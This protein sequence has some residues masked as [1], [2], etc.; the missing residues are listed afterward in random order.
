MDSA[1]HNRRVLILILVASAVMVLVMSI[2]F[3]VI[4]FSPA[5][6]KENVSAEVTQTPG[7]DE[8]VAALV[9]TMLVST[10]I[11]SP[12][13]PQPGEEAASLNEDLPAATH[14]PDPSP[15]AAPAA[16]TRATPTPNPW[17]ESA[18]AN[19]TLAQKVGQM[20]LTGVNGTALTTENCQ[21]I[22]RLSPG[23]ILYLS[24]NISSPYPDQLAFLSGGLQDC[25]TSING[26][27]LFVAIDH[28]GVYVSRFPYDSQM[29]IFPPAMAFGAAASPEFAY[30]AAS[31][32]G[33]ELRANGINMVLGPVA[34][35]LTNYDNTVISQRSFGGDPLAVS[36][37]VASAVQGY[38]AS[39]ILPV[40]KHYPG[41]GGVSGDSH[42]TLPADPA[43]LAQL[44]VTHLV[45]FQ[46][47]IESGAP[48]VMV[49]HVAFPEIDAQGLPASLSPPLYDLLYDD[50]GF[51]G[52][53]MSDSMGM[54]A[55]A[56]TGLSIEAASVQA[57]NAGLD[58]LMLVSPDLAE[59][60][61]G[62]IIN[63]VQS[64]EISMFRIDQAVRRILAV[65]AG[66][67]LF[68]AVA[69]GS[70]AP[71]W[72]RHAELAY[73]IGYQSVSLYKDQAGLVPLP[74]DIKDILIVGPAD[75]WGLYPLLRR[76]LD[77]RGILYNIMTFSDYWFGPVPETSYLQIV[78]AR[79]P[80]YDLVMVFTWDS[81]P[82]RFRFDD[83]FQGQLVNALLAGGHPL[84]VI[85]L[86][87][88][89]D[90]LDFPAV[91]TYLSSMGTSPG[92]LQGIVDALLG[93]SQPAGRIPLPNLP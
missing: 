56:G 71:D 90:I 63:A 50:L 81:H 14:T 32:A 6:Q 72:N 29:T 67:G 11:P 45:S 8:T 34:D 39:G 22:Q 77:Q 33:Q 88:P 15:S 59:S 91:S 48:A 30:Q 40:L 16:E 70:P 37:L 38:L 68:S 66:Y 17:V 25:M 44:A 57:V 73:Q 85:A 31:A 51:Q 13:P 54:G 24:T 19:M 89:T 49:S 26:L 2:L 76:S 27:P 93:V 36:D 28:E 43:N 47:G 92:Q 9:S 35:V 74:A 20:I 65:K 12:T 78:P 42:T 82:N 84:V 58:M 46:G 1:A 87:S 52:F 79:A 86:K 64:G 60:V 41:H 62:A 4:F 21:F 10:S 18:L 53:S 80:E 3:G 23:G 5:F 83:T 61:H 69:Q 7:I 55:I 75:G